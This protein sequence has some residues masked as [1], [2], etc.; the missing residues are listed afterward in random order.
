[1]SRIYPS[2]KIN[3]IVYPKPSTLVYNS[4]SVLESFI[5]YNDIEPLAIETITIKAKK[6]EWSSSRILKTLDFIDLIKY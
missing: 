4:P 3:F 5:D 6:K 2:G 1:M